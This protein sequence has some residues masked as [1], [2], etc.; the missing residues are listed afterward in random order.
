MFTREKLYTSDGG[1]VTEIELPAYDPKPDVMIW[2]ARVFI[3]VDGF[4]P[5]DFDPLD[6]VPVEDMQSREAYVEAFAYHIPIR[7]GDLPAA[8]TVRIWEIDG[9]EEWYVAAS[10]EEVK[11]C[12]SNYYGDPKYVDDDID[13]KPLEDSRLDALTYLE[14][15][16]DGEGVTKRTFRE[17]LALM[18]DN[19]DSFPCFFA[20]VNI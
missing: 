14:E 5:A 20:T 13:I 10:I 4:V 19:G 15:N 11:E 12:M 17:Q 18:I 9:G 7:E 1:Y 6:T 3:R 2:G 16:A 8:Q